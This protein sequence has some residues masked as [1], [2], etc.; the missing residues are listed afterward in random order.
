MS[1]IFIKLKEFT[2]RIIKGK[3]SIKC[4]HHNVH[5]GYVKVYSLIPFD[6]MSVPYHCWW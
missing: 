4:H 2:Y 1:N 3:F 6:A 5:S